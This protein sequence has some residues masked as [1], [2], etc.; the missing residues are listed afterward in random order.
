MKSR[1]VLALVAS[2]AF[3]G[4]SP[5]TSP[6]APSVPPAQAGQSHNRM[7][8]AVQSGGIAAEAESSAPQTQASTPKS[9]AAKADKAD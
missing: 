2:F 1:F 9:G 4:C 8:S 7:S 3:L 5:Q 6:P